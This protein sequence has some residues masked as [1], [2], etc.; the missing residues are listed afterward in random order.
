[1][2][3]AGKVGQEWYATAVTKFTK[4]RDHLIAEPCMFF[5]CD[6]VLGLCLRNQIWEEAGGMKRGGEGRG[7]VPKKQETG[8][9]DQRE[10]SGLEMLLSAGNWL[11]C[12]LLL[13]IHYNTVTQCFASKCIQ[14]EGV[15]K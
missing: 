12:G 5:F 10:H 15:P 7:G 3:A 9:K 6:S 1:M 8:R 2:N 4:P 11:L 13:A 14:R